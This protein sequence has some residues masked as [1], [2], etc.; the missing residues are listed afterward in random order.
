MITAN[1]LE[2]DLILQMNLVKDG[3][4]MPEEVVCYLYDRYP[5]LE[6]VF[7]SIRQKRKERK[8]ELIIKLK[9]QGLNTKQIA[10][11][12][13]VSSRHVRRLSARLRAEDS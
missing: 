3:Q 4:R 13:G 10:E 6:Q 2:E 1:S 11:R 5:K 7:R 9:E 12:I 8:E